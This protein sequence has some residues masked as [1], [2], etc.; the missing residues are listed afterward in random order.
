MAD[1]PLEVV[2]G[3]IIAIHLRADREARGEADA[4]W[5]QLLFHF[6]KARILAAHRR[7]I[8]EADLFEWEYQAL[9]RHTHDRF[10]LENYYRGVLSR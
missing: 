6:A 1:V 9:G 2:I 5:A 7:Q 4:L 10:G 3:K 8:D